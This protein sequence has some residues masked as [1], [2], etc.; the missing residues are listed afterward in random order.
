ME[1]SALLSELQQHLLNYLNGQTTLRQFEEWF[2]PATWDVQDTDNP[3]LI[4]TR[5]AIDARIAEYTNGD[6]S[7]GELRNFLRPYVETKV[8][9]F[10][11]NA[12]STPRQ[13]TANQSSVRRVSLTFALVGG[14]EAPLSPNTLV[15]AT[16]LATRPDTLD[17]QTERNPHEQLVFQA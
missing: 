10:P 1:T 5:N 13:H 4:E 12:S 7:E 15:L 9:A 6:W 2:V 3:Q 17:E 11:S 8:I 14:P 16:V